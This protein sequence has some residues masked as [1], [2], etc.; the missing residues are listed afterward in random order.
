MIEQVKTSQGL[1][2]TEQSASF[3]KDAIYSV[4]SFIS[5]VGVFREAREGGLSERH[6]GLQVREREEL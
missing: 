5:V 3:N 4:F 1:E 2:S 6:T